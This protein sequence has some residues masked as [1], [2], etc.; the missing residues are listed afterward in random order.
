MRRL[1][2]VHGA[3]PTRTTPDEASPPQC[4]MDGDHLRGKWVQNCAPESIKRPDLYARKGTGA[5]HWTTGTTASA[6]GSYAERAIASGTLMDM[7]T[8]RLLD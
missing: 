4:R 8:Q 3:L 5:H 6:T 7:A 1:V 2:Q